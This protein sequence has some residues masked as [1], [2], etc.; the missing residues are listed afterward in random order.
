MHQPIISSFQ[1]PSLSGLIIKDDRTP[2]ETLPGILEFS[3]NLPQTERVISAVKNDTS[4]IPQT[5]DR[6][7]YH[8][9]EHAAWWLNG[10]D[11]MHGILGTAARLDINTSGLTY[12]E[13]GCASGRVVRHFAHQTDAKIWCAD[14]NL[15]HTEWIRKF[16]PPH[17]KAFNNTAFP[18]LPIESNSVDIAS[19]FSVFT[20]ID[21]LELMWIAE[22][23]R[24]IR[25]GGMAYITVQTENTWEKYKTGWIKDVLMPMASVIPDYEIGLHTFEE[26]LP[27]EKTV[28][29][30]QTRTVYNS[31]VFHTTDY[32][33]R[34]WSRFFN[35]IEIIPNGSTYQDVIVLQKYQI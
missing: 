22:L 24:I 28:Y 20:H 17:I 5:K 3:S 25:P 4:P 26:P 8:G 16:L 19:A 6:E 1:T 11:D 12:F 23:A 14:I 31:T 9:D 13:M 27:K 35:V 7:Y 18:Y 29:W 10:L 15:R 30:W 32:L 34:E 2:F 21:D 33:R